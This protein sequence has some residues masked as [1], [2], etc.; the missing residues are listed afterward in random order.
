MNLMGDRKKK[1]VR[2]EAWSYNRE[3]N[4]LTR[5]L[6][7][8]ITKLS[9]Y[10]TGYITQ[11]KNEEKPRNLKQDIICLGL[12]LRLN[13]ICSLFAA[14]FSFY[15]QVQNVHKYL[16]YIEHIVS[17]CLKCWVSTEYTKGIYKIMHV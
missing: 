17:K 14:I 9:H 10:T 2:R 12:D 1:A 4:P 5:P 16:S 15:F 11:W 6:D 13:F 8:N 3:T 7:F